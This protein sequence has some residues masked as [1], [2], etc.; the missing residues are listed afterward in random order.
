MSIDRHGLAPYSGFQLQDNSVFLKFLVTNRGKQTPY[1]I[2]QGLP[3]DAGI[4]AYEQSP[5]I[6][7][8]NVPSHN[9]QQ[10]QRNNSWISINA[11][12]PI[13]FPKSSRRKTLSSPLPAID[14]RP[15]EKIAINKGDNITTVMLL[16]KRRGYL[17]R[18]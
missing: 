11:N 13:D 5:S 8:G 1:L 12:P 2:G 7:V 15:V 14:I 16:S 6:L 18:G 3:L 4:G 9:S 10:K 17:N